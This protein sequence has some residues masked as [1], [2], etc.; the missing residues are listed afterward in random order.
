MSVQHHPMALYRESDDNMKLSIDNLSGL[1]NQ[2]M[3][4]SFRIDAERR[5]A[6]PATRAA[7]GI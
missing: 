5:G 4:F 6:E 3:R 7:S 1:F 2:I